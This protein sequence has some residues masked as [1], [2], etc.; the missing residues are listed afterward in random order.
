MEKKAGLLLNIHQVELL[1]REMEAGKG[2]QLRFYHKMADQYPLGSDERLEW[3]EEAH[4]SFMAPKPGRGPRKKI[5]GDL[6]ALDFMLET[7]WNSAEHISAR[8]LAEVAVDKGL[9]VQRGG[10]DAQI[11]RLA[12]RLTKLP[13]WRRHLEKHGRCK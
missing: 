9:A 10:R 8:R 1:Q 5:L 6:E 7:S 11:Q 12:R 3:L 2:W 4:R 13:R